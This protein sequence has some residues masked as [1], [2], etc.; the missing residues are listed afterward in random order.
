MLNNDPLWVYSFEWSY[1]PAVASWFGCRCG[2]GG[3]LSTRCALIINS[4]AGISMPRRPYE[5]TPSIV[6]VARGFRYICHLPSVMFFR[7]IGKTRSTRFVC[8]LFTKTWCGSMWKR[9]STSIYYVPWW[10][11]FESWSMVKPATTGGC[12]QNMWYQNEPVA[13]HQERSWY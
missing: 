2:S 6:E 11:L 10:I 12:T 4:V 7:I 3:L 5:E 9:R 13:N 8:W 1:S